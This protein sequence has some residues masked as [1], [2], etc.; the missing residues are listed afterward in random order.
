MWRCTSG[1][2]CFFQN[3][4]QRTICLTRSQVTLIRSVSEGYKSQSLADVSGYNPARKNV[5]LSHAEH[6]VVL[7][8]ILPRRFVV[9]FYFAQCFADEPA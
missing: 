5:I 4:V 9:A 1:G 2:N 8:T 7:S 3:V 6:S